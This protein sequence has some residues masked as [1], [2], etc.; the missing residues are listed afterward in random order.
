MTEDKLFNKLADAIS[1]AFKPGGDPTEACVLPLDDVQELM[2]IMLKCSILGAY[3]AIWSERPNLHQ[4]DPELW[5]RIIVD[6]R[7]L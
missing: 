5:G 1:A 4:E 2:D 6:A 7:P 3:L